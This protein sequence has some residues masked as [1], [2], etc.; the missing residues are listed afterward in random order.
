MLEAGIPLPVIKNFLGHLS[1]EVTMIYATVSD[2]LKN[3]YIKDNSIAASIPTDIENLSQ[4]RNDK[5]STGIIQI[6]P[7]D[8]HP[9]S[10]LYLSTTRVDSELLSVSDVRRQAHL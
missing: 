6:P 8:G 2:E 4:A 5:Y 10:W 1:I 7:H 3:K 9:W